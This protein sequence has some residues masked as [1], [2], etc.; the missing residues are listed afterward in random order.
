MRN[1]SHFV[2][3]LRRQN[4]K[5]PA[6]M[7]RSLLRDSSAN[8]LAITAAAVLPMIALTGSAI[9]ISRVYLAKGR[10]QA[11]CDS[12]VLA[13]RKAMTTLIYTQAAQTR[14]RSMFDFNFEQDDYGSNDTNFSAVADAEGKL[15]GTATTTLP[16]I[17]MNM[18][19]MGDSDI[20]VQCSA[21]IQVPNID[22]VFVLDVTGSMDDTIGGT[23]K[24]A[25]LKTATI[26]FYDSIA[27][28]MAGNTRTRVR[29]GF[30]P[31]SQI[32]NGSELFR[33]NPNFDTLGQL[34]MGHVI[35]LQTVQSRV[36]NFNTPVLGAGVVDPTW[37]IKTYDQRYNSTNATSKAPDAAV[38]PTGTLISTADCD[39]YSSNLSFEVTG[40]SPL[41]KA[42]FPMNT[43][44]PGDQGLGSSALYKLTETSPWTA[45]EP[46]TASS[47]IKATFSRVSA[48]WTDN[49]GAQTGNYKACTRRVTHTRYVRPTNYK[50]TNWTYQPV[51]YNVTNFA[52][53]TPIS[54]VT[55]IDSTALLPTAGP[56][57][58]VQLAAMANQTGFTRTT[59]SW[60]GCLEERSTSKGATTFSPIPAD[61]KDLDYIVGGTGPTTRWRPMNP[62]LTWMRPSNVS[63][64]T[65]ATNGRPGVACPTASM[66]N[67]REYSNR[68]DF[69]TYVNSLQPAGNT[70]L[71]VGMVW[72][73]RFIVPQGL[74]AQRNLTGPNGGQISRHIIFLTDG[75][76][77]SSAETYSA[78]GVEQMQREIT[79]TSGVAAATLHARRFQALCDA[80]RGRVGIWAVAFGT[81]VT[82][83]LTN[84]ADSGRAMQANN[85]TE[86]RSAF[87]RI[88]NEVADLRL[89][90]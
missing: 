76:P 78:Y 23:K 26:G 31:Y 43:T 39:F 27:A 3:P 69:T 88:A 37:Q 81:S 71:D 13:G 19:G 62:D 38:N 86:L 21:D 57:S 6:G 82:G 46:L 74:F 25:S 22:I 72:G 8:V 75:E 41:I 49:N 65:T 14:A 5:K 24:I 79:G 9:D 58:V 59:T 29:Y 87:S 68:S 18:M 56:Y 83:N 90:E 45:T 34:P 51:N 32:V 70:Y 61:A 52:T 64:T 60:N 77:V 10:L 50:F 47:Y 30:V 73:L 11:A 2:N 17:V 28:A 16:M 55:A 48:T 15:T 12:G 85:T 80:E 44:Y 20:D 7:L 67:L 84:C 4:G 63:Q 89:V 33:P 42:F 35:D 40:S 54:Y 1:F 53:G 66:R 36:A